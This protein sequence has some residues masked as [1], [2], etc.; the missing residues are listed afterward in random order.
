MNAANGISF[1]S[2]KGFYDAASVS[3]GRIDGLLSTV[4]GEIARVP[5]TVERISRVDGILLPGHGFD[6]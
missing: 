3:L 6:A 4:C 5:T 1:E 2:T